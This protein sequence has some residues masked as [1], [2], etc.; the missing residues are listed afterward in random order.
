MCP[1]FAS[2]TVEK[3]TK[4]KAVSLQQKCAAILACN[5]RHDHYIKDFTV[6]HAIQDE[7]NAYFHCYGK[8]I[9]L[10]PYCSSLQS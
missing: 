9:M 10:S 7:S 4:H 2:A 1:T 3:K 8:C 6:Q 5:F